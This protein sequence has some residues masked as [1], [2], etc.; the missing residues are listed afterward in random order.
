MQAQKQKAEAQAAYDTKTAA[1]RAKRFDF[2]IS[3]ADIFAHFMADRKKSASSLGGSS[4]TDGTTVPKK[5]GRPKKGSEK[6]SLMVARP[7]ESA[8]IDTA[9]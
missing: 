5:R 3:Q 1:D 9:E 8:A 4:S 6:S 2:L 7:S